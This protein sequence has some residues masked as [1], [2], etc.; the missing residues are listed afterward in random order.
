MVVGARATAA[1]ALVASLA[2]RSRVTAA[3]L[4][5][6]ATVMQAPAPCA[7]TQALAPCVPTQALARSAPTQVPAPSATAVEAEVPA[8]TLRKGVAV[9]A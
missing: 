8:A 5:R 1:V 4:L 9:D 6:G 7:P 2:T 3:S